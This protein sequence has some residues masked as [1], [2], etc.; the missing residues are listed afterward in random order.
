MP[1]VVLVEVVVVT[2]VVL[3]VLVSDGDVV[4]VVAS[5]DD[6]E[7]VVDVDVLV[8]VTQFPSPSQASK[9]LTN[10]GHDTPFFSHF[11]ALAAM[12][13]FT[14]PLPFRWQQA[15]LPGF[16]QVDASEHFL[17]AAAHGP[18]SVPS[19]LAALVTPL[20]HLTYAFRVDLSPGSQLQL[21]AISSRTA[22]TAAA[23]CDAGHFLVSHTAEATVGAPTKSATAHTAGRE[24]ERRF[25]AT[26]AVALMA[27]P[28]RGWRWPSA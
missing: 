2:T 5:V 20:T 18:V 6:V 14:A 27:P 11:A 13:A 3:D 7:V 1:N 28:A 12:L 15:T 17:A 24:V 9:A 16:P 25:L 23:N 21:S 8:V 19:L 26:R 22:S 4:V 10:A